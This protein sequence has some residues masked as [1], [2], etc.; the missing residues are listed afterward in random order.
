MVNPYDAVPYATC[1]IEWLAPERLALASLLHG[2]PRM[3]L[4]R[5]RYLELGCGN[6]ANLLPLAYYRRNGTFVGIDAAP[7][8][9]ALGQSW[10]NALSLENLSLHAADFAS[11]APLLDEPFDFVVVHGVYSWISEADREALLQ[12]CREHLC[13]RGLLYISYNARPG[14]DIRGL[15]RNFLQRQLSPIPQGMTQG[16]SAQA[17]CTQLLPFLKLT[18]HPFSHLMA[19]ELDLLLGYQPSY[20]VHD[21][22]APHNEAFWRSEFLQR[23]A[24]SGFV[25]VADADF[26]HPSGRVQEQLPQQLRKAG[27]SDDALGDTLDL[28]SYRQFHCALL[29]RSSISLNPLQD[30]ELATMNLSSP[31]R[32]VHSAVDGPTDQFEHPTG[33]TVQAPTEPMLGALQRLYLLYPDGAPIGQLFAETPIPRDDL[34]LLIRNGLLEL[35][36]GELPWPAVDPGLLH[37]LEYAHSGFCTS[38]GHQRLDMTSRNAP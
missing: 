38:P 15:V 12:L 4:R 8:A 26:N 9:C 23:M 29:T 3:D 14:W 11:A 24:D 21:Y 36:F 20:V 7:A 16:Q 33:Y 31:M 17:L 28:V 22:L 32:P 6:G 10:V 19:S 13:P 27:I 5:F 18:D 2:G 30:R 1:P 37:T 34:L 25:Y 35:T